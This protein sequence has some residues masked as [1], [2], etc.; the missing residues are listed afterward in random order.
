MRDAAHRLLPGGL[1]TGGGLRRDYA[2]RAVDGALELAL[3]QAAAEAAHVPE[4]VTRVL[5]C[6]LDSL[7]GA[8]PEPARIAA[9]CVADRQ[10]LMGEL[11]RHLGAGPRWLVAA[12]AACGARFDMQVDPAALPVRPAGA[13]FP[14]LRL[15]W[16]GQEQVLRVPDGSDQAWLAEQHP[17]GPTRAAGRAL[18]ARL[19]LHIDGRPADAGE[20]GA[21][22]EA[23]LDAVDA[24]LDETAPAL[25]TQGLAECPECGHANTVAFDPYGALA[26]GGGE[27]LDEVHE[28]ASHYHW[29]ERDIL[30]LPRTRR[31]DY[32]RRIEARGSH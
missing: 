16:N 27:L 4:A 9:L 12:C 14:R 13:G 28:L 29:S 18:A 30:A 25:A 17:G 8:A 23:W 31:R 21:L 1:A 11:E 22:P 2:F 7:A 24:A 15:A 19:L 6:A 10:L 5:G 26:R 32:L 20:A 3:A